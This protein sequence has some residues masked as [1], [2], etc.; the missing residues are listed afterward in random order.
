MFIDLSDAY[1]ME[2][3]KEEIKNGSKY[4]SFNNYRKREYQ[5]T[6]II[7]EDKVIKKA[8][9]K[10]GI[11]NF[12]NICNNIEFLNQYTEFEILDKYTKD[13]LYS[14]Y[15]KNKNT[16][17]IEFVK[18]NDNEYVVKTLNEIKDILLK[19]SVPYNKSEIKKYNEIIE[20]EEEK[21]KMMKLNYLEY[22]FYDMVP[23]N[24]FYID[25]K[26][27]FFDQEWM[28]KWIP[29]EFVIYRSVINSYDLVGKINVD[30]L[31]EKLGILEYKEIF[32]KID[33]E[34][35]KKILNKDV[36]DA[37]NY[38]N[39]KMYE[40]LYKKVELE[41]HNKNYMEDNKNKQEYI[42]KLE[43]EIKQYR[44]E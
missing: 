28:E 14:N 20:N 21:E 3:S 38:Q 23:K 31:L 29:V 6:T 27:C 7:Q 36:F 1:F 25:G 15:I 18:N 41:I 43:N 2:I 19:H 44:K 40:I 22:G 5:L 34:L 30:E 32:I 17:D 16:L 39:S 4:I 8:T 37:L 33:N 11:N 24:C 35:R 42:E 13:Y 26:Y 10:E 12:K 9:D